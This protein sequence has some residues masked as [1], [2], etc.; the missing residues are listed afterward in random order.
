MVTTQLQERIEINEEH[1]TRLVAVY[2][3]LREGHGNWA[4]ILKGNAKLLG[5]YTSEPKYTMYSAGGFPIVCDNGT[6]TIVYEVYEVDSNAVMRRLHSLEGCTGIP[7]HENNWYDI[8][9]IET[10]HGTA[11]MYVQHEA[12]ER[13]SIIKNGNWNER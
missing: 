3:T 12:G 9:P 1:P 6:G 5:T 13:M 4:A 7:G 11:Y 2:G 8:Q 10:P